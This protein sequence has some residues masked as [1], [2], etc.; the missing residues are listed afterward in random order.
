M[1]IVREEHFEIRICRFRRRVA[2]FDSAKRLLSLDQFLNSPG[3]CSGLLDTQEKHQPHGR[4]RQSCPVCTKPKKCDRSQGPRDTQIPQVRRQQSAARGLCLQF[5][6]HRWFLRPP[7]SGLEIVGSV[8]QATEL[9]PP[10]LVRL[11]QQDLFG[12]I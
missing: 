8:R 11:C 12:R 6:C 3:V 9:K 10:C 1:N 2:I 4:R 7:E 5:E